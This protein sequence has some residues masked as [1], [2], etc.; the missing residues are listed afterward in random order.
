MKNWKY[1]ALSLCFAVSA[2]LWY[3]TAE[4]NHPWRVRFPYITL[5]SFVIM[6]LSVVCLKV[7]SRTWNDRGDR[8]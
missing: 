1:H 5:I 6:L 7:M 4:A 3:A 8:E 2:G